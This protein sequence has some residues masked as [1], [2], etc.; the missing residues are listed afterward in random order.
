MLQHAER[1]YRTPFNVSDW[2]DPKLADDPRWK[3]GTP[4]QSNANFAWVQHFIYHLSPRGPP[5][6][7]S[8]T[9]RC[10]RRRAARARYA[11]GWSRR[12][13][14]TALSR[15]RTGCSIT[16]A[17]RSV[18][19]SSPDR[20]G[21]GHRKR[22]GEVL[23]IDARKLGTMVT[24]KLRELS[25]G[26]IARIADAYHC[27]RHHDGGYVDVP[28]FCKA[29]RLDEIKHHGFVLAPGRYVGTEEAE[30]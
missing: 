24:R 21:N 3:Y 10:R 20:H 23:F 14:W 18:C 17:S 15:C 6:S 27:W 7:S 1:V 16:P 5:G 9:G 13:W 28:G 12:T 26:D 2:W 4:P 29:A 8:P 19:G 22:Q 11:N 30:G 25:E